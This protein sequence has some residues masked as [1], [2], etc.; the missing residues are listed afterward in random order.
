MLDESLTITFD[1]STTS[2]SVWD[3]DLEVGLIRKV[4]NTEE[5]RAEIR[6]T[7]NAGAD[8]IK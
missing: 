3:G 1:R 6:A 4:V 8:S 2:I 7:M 5:A